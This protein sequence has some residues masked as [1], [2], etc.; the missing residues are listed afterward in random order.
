MNKTKMDDR[1][2]SHLVSVSWGHLWIWDFMYFENIMASEGLSEKVT[3]KLKI[4]GA[5][6]EHSGRLD[7]G[8]W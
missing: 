4:K 8:S 3:L 7:D 1:L 5:S 6:H 2:E